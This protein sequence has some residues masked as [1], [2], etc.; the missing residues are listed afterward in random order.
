MLVGKDDKS[1]D[2]VIS[3]KRKGKSNKE[4]KIAKFFVPCLLMSAGD[5]IDACRMR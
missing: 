3:K 4:Q 2:K 5:A 1:R